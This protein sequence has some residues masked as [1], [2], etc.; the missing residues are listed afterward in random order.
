MTS[1]DIINIR[2]AAQQITGTK[3]KSPQKIVSWLGAMQAQ[4]YPMSKWAVGVRLPGSTQADIEKAVD[5]GK[6]IR[7]HVLRP[8]WHLV[9]SEDIY[10]MLE[11]TAPHIKVLIR[12]QEKKL[13]LTEAL[14]IKSRKIIEKSLQKN[15]AMTRKELMAD[16]NKAGINTSDI[17]SAYL[18]F[19]AE[20]DSVVCNGIPKENQQTYSLLAERVKRKSPPLK[21]EEAAAKLA[22][23]YFRS[24]CP[25]TLKDFIWWSGLPVKDAKAALENISSR[26]MTETIGTEKYYLTD[27]FKEAEPQKNSLYLLPAYDEFIISY[28]NRDAAIPPENRGKAFTN[29]GLFKALI[30]KDGKVIGVWKRVSEKDK[31]IIETEFFQS[32]RNTSLAPVKKAAEVYGEFIGK[33]VVV[34][35]LIKILDL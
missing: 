12:S 18:M 5:S 23:I 30:V 29:N 14:Y 15:K 26:L 1:H 19:R 22:G 6:I 2:L 27:T 31:V 17:R 25:A 13:E 32:Y 3:F 20:I 16:L 33:E 10:W 24:H 34:K 9:S 35:N 4:D 28:T 11:L 8:T 7:T 21:R